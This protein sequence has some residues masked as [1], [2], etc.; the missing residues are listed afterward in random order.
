MTSGRCSRSS[1][2]RY[3]QRSSH[4]RIVPCYPHCAR[5]LVFCPLLQ[6]APEYCF[7]LAMFADVLMSENGEEAG[8]YAIA[9]LQSALQIAL[10]AC[11]ALASEAK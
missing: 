9:M 2:H 7:L 11:A 4:F 10:D 5:L 1:L 6:V 8:K 3:L